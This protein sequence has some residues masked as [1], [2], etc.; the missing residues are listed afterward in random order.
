MIK[1]IIALFFLN[2]VYVV[3]AQ[4]TTHSDVFEREVEVVQE[5]PPQKDT[6]TPI[7]RSA[8]IAQYKSQTP[9]EPPSQDA[10]SPTDSPFV[11]PTKDEPAIPPV[12]K[13]R[14]RPAK[15]TKEALIEG[16]VSFPSDQETQSVPQHSDLPQETAER[17][18]R[19]IDLVT[20]A[21]AARP[22]LDSDNLSQA[23]TPETPNAEPPQAEKAPK[24]RGRGRP[25][26]LP[27]EAPSTES[28]ALDT[29]QD[30]P[31]AL[32]TPETAP[33][34]IKDRIY[35]RA[36]SLKN[37]AQ[38]RIKKFGSDLKDSAYSKLE[39]A[40][41][42]LQDHAI[43][44]KN[45]TSNHLYALGNTIKD[46]A[47]TYIYVPRPVKHL[48]SNISYRYFKNTMNLMKSAYHFFK[49][50]TDVGHRVVQHI[51]SDVGA[52][53][54]V[55]GDTVSGATSAGLPG[56]AISLAVSAG[57]EMAK[58]GLESLNPMITIM[59]T[60]Q[61]LGHIK[62][63]LKAFFYFYACV[64]NGAVSFISDAGRTLTSYGSY[65]GNFLKDPEE[66]RFMVDNYAFD[67]YFKWLVR[68]GILSYSVLYYAEMGLVDVATGG[69]NLTHKLSLV[70]K[71]V[72]SAVDAM[73]AHFSPVLEAKG[74]RNQASALKDVLFNSNIQMKR[75]QQFIINA[76]SNI[77]T[78]LNA[79]EFMNER[80][81]AEKGYSGIA[82]MISGF[83]NLTNTL[84][85]AIKYENTR[86]EGQIF[87]NE[88]VNNA[89]ETATS[90]K[91]T[92]WN[93]ASMIAD[94]ASSAFNTLKNWVF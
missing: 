65:L 82:S 75:I 61:S 85:K 70:C 93:G 64:E 55:V 32:N 53:V 67:K 94:K 48:A 54:S 88:T 46:T 40:Q 66:F 25:K 1:I 90:I 16:P 91:D 33:A 4:D 7:R 27:V 76:Q 38:A 44:L 87:V 24:K 5:D 6:P 69:V 15:I 10:V 83:K 31:K 35:T 47:S 11:T 77:A 13:K 63:I 73:K 8:R 14:G 37:D 18:E 59:Q 84:G 72:Q 17:E 21:I 71:S 92:V 57:K 51:E 74:W 62:A 50:Y 58:F 30:P 20:E 3:Q 12:K 2:S 49:M 79:F 28:I 81:W 23:A 43:R 68:L 26:K 78:S 42:A 86:L 9:E 60:L 34:S 41:S 36:Q 56:A 19:K 52:A 89:T 39:S 80:E 45:A 29:P 22:T